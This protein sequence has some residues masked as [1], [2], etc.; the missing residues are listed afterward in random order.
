MSRRIRNSR[1][2]DQLNYVWLAK[3]S[4]VA[5]LCTCGTTPLPTHEATGHPA[6]VEHCGRPSA[7]S[8]CA[9]QHQASGCFCHIDTSII[10]ESLCCW[11]GIDVALWPQCLL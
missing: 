8:C 2:L 7:T 6:S 9:L 1:R 5:G 11:L 4:F 10:R 3:D